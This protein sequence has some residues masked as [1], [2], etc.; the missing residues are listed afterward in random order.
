MTWR[1]PD[2]LLARVR[3]QAAER[4]R[5]MND[6]VTELLSAATDPRHAGTEAERVRERLRAAGLLAGRVERA[7]TRPS[8]ADLSK[9][10]AA[11]ATG[12]PLS[13]LVIRDR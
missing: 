3:Q 10:R 8:P 6:W 4:G 1:A 7:V 11:A 9:A 13:E 5:S 12:S 2:D